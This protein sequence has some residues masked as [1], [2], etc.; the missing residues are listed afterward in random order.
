MNRAPFIIILVLL[1]STLKAQIT[2]GDFY[3]NSD[4]VKFLE[5]SA[6]PRNS[7]SLLETH[8]E[9]S[10]TSRE[11][12]E[13]VFEIDPSHH[14]DLQIE[15]HGA[16]NIRYLISS[17]KVHDETALVGPGSKN[18]SP[19]ADDN[20][21]SLID[22]FPGLS[23]V[24]AYNSQIRSIPGTGFT[25]LIIP[26]QL[27]KKH[28]ESYRLKMKIEKDTV[29]KEKVKVRL[30]QRKKLKANFAGRVD[31]NVFIPEELAPNFSEM[32]QNELVDRL[33]RIY[34]S[35]GIYFRIQTLSHISNE[36]SHPKL[37]ALPESL[38]MKA[39]LQ[40]GGLSLVICYSISSCALGNVAG[41][42]DGIPGPSSIE[43]A[44]RRRVY[45]ALPD[46][47]KNIDSG[48]FESW[49]IESGNLLAHEIGHYLGLAHTYERA[50]NSLQDT[51]S[52]TPNV[53]SNNVMDPLINRQG[54]PIFSFKQIDQL[55]AHP[56]VTPEL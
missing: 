42:S 18:K 44:Q 17:L 41:F 37:E 43:G 25:S 40:D 2:C 15:V 21:L 38:G 55:R 10:E 47:P 6:D 13:V 22:D 54:I 8:A 28:K 7:R 46:P 50:S 45:V 5:T 24:S 29:S 35:A 1:A 51:F 4:I 23:D 34:E 36:F 11:S 33:N 39:D 49:L 19:K 53:D 48:V 20:L 31:L 26:F 9:F 56:I 14:G 3:K 32:K 16:A 30:V 12:H 52:D 27:L